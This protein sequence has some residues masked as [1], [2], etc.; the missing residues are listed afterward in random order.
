[1]AHPKVEAASMVLEF[2]VTNPVIMIKIIDERNR[3]KNKMDKEL[4]PAL[5]AFSIV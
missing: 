2:F 3:L 1:M 4:L 5:K